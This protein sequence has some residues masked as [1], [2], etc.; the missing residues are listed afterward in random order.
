MRVAAGQQGFFDPTLEPVQKPTA[1][2]RL[3]V[4]ITVKAAPNP[5]AT[6]GETV[7]VAGISAD[8]TSPGWIRLYPINF[9]DLDSTGRFRKY[10]LVEVDA[11]PAPNDPRAESW[12]PVMP[13]LTVIRNLP[14]WA[15][16]RPFVDPYVEDSMCA[17]NADSLLAGSRS[18]AAIRV[19]DVSDLVVEPH[20]GWTAEDRRR[21]T[22]TSTNSTC[23]R[24]ATRPRWKLHGSGPATSGDARLVAARGTSRAS[25][26]GSSWHFSG[27]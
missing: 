18:L 19:N 2:R 10:D 26:T 14:P 6:Y 27:T 15:K 22:D 5:S 24:P 12:R 8:L 25:S 9:R 23:L 21:S 1:K 3:S 17:L 4:L 7:C 16:R 11:A 13:T 20:P